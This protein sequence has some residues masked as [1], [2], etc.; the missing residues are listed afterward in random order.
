MAPD[1]P[2]PPMLSGATPAASDHCAAGSVTR[3][4][5]HHANKM[6]WQN[7]AQRQ[8]KFRLY[9]VRCCPQPRGDLVRM[10]G[11]EDCAAGGAGDS[12]KVSH[13]FQPS[14]RALLSNSP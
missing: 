2:I 6:S 11:G 4:T 14:G 7:F 12:E 5:P 1:I 8:A 9:T 10:G 13:R 3:R